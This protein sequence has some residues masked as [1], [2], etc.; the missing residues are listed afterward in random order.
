MT[1]KA[2][3]VDVRGRSR[4]LRVNYRTSYQIRTQ[5][6]RLLGPVVVDV[7]GNAD[8]RSDTVSVFSGPPPTIQTYK[9]HDEEIRA[10]GTCW[11]SMVSSAP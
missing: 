9:N 5:A 10:V 1:W 4:T 2:L 7:D 6:D 3:G 11:P 8:D